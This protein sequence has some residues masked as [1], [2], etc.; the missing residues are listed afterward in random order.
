MARGGSGGGDGL[1]AGAARLVPLAGERPQDD[2]AVLD[3]HRAVRAGDLEA[4]GESRVDRGAGDDRPDRAGGE[5][6]QRERGV[7]DLDLVRL[8]RADGGDL[9]GRAHGP[10]QQVHVVDALVQQRP[11]VQFPCAA[12]GRAVVVALGAVPLGAGLAEQQRAE[13][14][15]VQQAAQLIQPGIEPVLR[16]HG[17][18][19]AVPARGRDEPAGRFQGDVDRLLH[20]EVLARRGRLGTDLGVQAARH[21]HRHHVDVIPGKQR[22]QAGLGRAVPFAGQGLGPPG[23]HVGDRGQ[24]GA[25]DQADGLSVHRADHAGAD[26]AEPVAPGAAVCVR[27][28]HRASRSLIVPSSRLRSQR[29][30]SR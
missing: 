24:P 18:Q 11:A 26:D 9:G 23:H 27:L 10:Q 17:D 7:L 12:P 6:H 5:P 1:A 2:P 15:G 3:D 29:P 22:R 28:A 14:T 4:L 21:A 20:H 30:G 16:D 8:G 25:G 13:G 19:D